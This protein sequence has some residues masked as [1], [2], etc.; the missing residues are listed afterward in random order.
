MDTIALSS[1]T[2]LTPHGRQASFA[3][4]E[5]TSDW[6]TIQSILAAD[7]YS[8]PAGL[9]GL[10]VD[11]GAHI[12]GWA[13]AAALDNPGASVVAIEALPE[14]L[15]LLRE[16]VERNSLGDRVGV[17][18]A[19]A[20]NR[21]A[22]A[23]RVYYGPD[24]VHRFI[25]DQRT[26][27]DEAFVLAPTATLEDLGPVRLLKIDCEGCEFR[28]L[29]SPAIAG[30]EE[31]TG[32]YHGPIEALEALLLPTHLVTWSGSPGFGKFKAIRR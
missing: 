17:V 28:F 11:V 22:A 31:V 3:V 15:E 18:G 9:A 26:P 27:R 14:N 23:E 30:V 10:L 13:I 19:S 29:A 2:W 32:E 24:A 20:S 6:N 25:G 5:G 4:R 12:G 16:N 21:R 8:I 1:G 7:E